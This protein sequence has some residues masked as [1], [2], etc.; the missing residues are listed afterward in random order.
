LL[1]KIIMQIQ[2]KEY[3]MKHYKY[4]II[5]GGM[6]G[7]AAI[8]GIRENDPDGSIALFTKEQF[9]PYKRPP[10]TKGLWADKDVKSI[11]ISL[12][13]F[14][15]D[16]YLETAIDKLSPDKKQVSASDGEEYQYQKL[17][18]AT[19]GDPRHL[20][21]EPEGV[22]YYRT[23]A[24]FQHLKHQTGYKEHFCIIGGGFVGSELA[25]ALTN[26]N[27][28]V[29]MIFPEAGISGTLFPDD[30][31]KFLVDYYQ[32]KG[33]AV[34]TG[35]LVDSI[36]KEDD[37]YIVK[38]H[39]IDDNSSAEDV[40]DAVIAGIGIK[41]NTALAEACGI[42]VDDGI[43]VNEYLQTNLPD[44]YAA[45]DIA[46]FLH[47]PLGKHVRVEHED[48]ANSMG[49]LVGKNMSGELKKYDHFPYFY[50]DLFDL[51]YEAVGEINNDL[52]TYEDW[53][54][55]F[56]QGT[57]FYL[58]DGQIRGLIFWNLWDKVEQGQAVISA[59]QTFQKSD[60]AG[61]FH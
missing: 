27:K 28:K 21:G 43:I 44:V 6:T 14:Q 11:I 9:P 53:V 45:G 30:L 39:S 51:G 20:P 5:G 42:E 10:L 16:L 37:H 40:F 4:I 8:K 49:K 61:M 60:L 26:N 24:D 31:A 2:A 47:I 1:A 34:L 19:G 55:P 33:V 36:H 41:P 58:Q 15:V 54:E 32:E 50:S 35:K 3:I 59:G 17:L 22:I 56:K 13:E 29:T 7:S 12:D 38:Y 18:L 52:E 23:L 57:I 46:N 48:N 25:A